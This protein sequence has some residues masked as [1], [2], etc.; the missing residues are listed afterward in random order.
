MIFCKPEELKEGQ[1]LAKPIYNKQGVLLYDRGSELTA[2]IIDSV[3][4]FGL[5]G[6]LILEPSEPLPPVT[7]EEL[8]FEQLQTAYMFR[9][10]DCL[11]AISKGNNPPDFKKLAS[12]ITERFGTVDHRAPFSQTIRSGDDY[13]YKHTI[14]TAIICA[15][16]AHK[17][18]M[19]KPSI[20]ELVEAALLADFGYLYVPKDI[21]NKDEED[22]TGVDL[23][24][25]EQ[26]RNK[27]F[28]LLQTDINPFGLH[29]ETIRVITEF[30]KCPRKEDT[31]LN[32]S[33]W[34]L[35][36]KVLMVAD[37]YD[38]MTAMSIIKDPVSGVAA[39]KHLK[40]EKIYEPFIVK[41]LGESLDLLPVGQ[42]IVLSNKVRGMILS[43]GKDAM[44][45]RILDLDNNKVYDLSDP[46]FKGTMEVAD[47]QQKMD[48]RYEFD[49]ETIKQFEPDEPLKNMTRRIR[50][51]MSNARKR[52]SGRVPRSAAPRAA[53]AARNPRSGR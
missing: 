53:G 30:L 17:L 15:L 9:L 22:L 20:E 3:K 32:I 26:Y 2:T 43:E 29:P 19:P 50:V 40:S 5:I 37:K 10:R 34:V 49:E 44:A 41:A 48:R 8:E 46:E 39:M 52:D 42:S 21:M 18:N 23:I 16:L 36:T 45:P 11:V 1:K 38:R 12:D 47:L 13:N 33:G 25:I 24:T 28:S 7:P 31:S 4:K 6:V 27:A 35:S 14:C 51:R